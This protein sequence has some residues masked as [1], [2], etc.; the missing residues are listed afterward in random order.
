MWQRIMR[1]SNE[2]YVLRLRHT[3]KVECPCRSK[4]DV[5]GKMT[6]T[7]RIAIIS[8]ACPIVWARSELPRWPCSPLLRFR[9]R[10][11]AG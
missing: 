6:T 9:D 10:V 3:R 7:S 5:A 1:H 4:A 11:P 8:A 2:I